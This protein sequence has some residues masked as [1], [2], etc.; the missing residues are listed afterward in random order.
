MVIRGDSTVEIFT[1]HIPAPYPS[2]SHAVVTHISQLRLKKPSTRRW[3]INGSPLLKVRITSY[4][5]DLSSSWSSFS[6]T[7][8]YLDSELFHLSGSVLQHFGL[9]RKQQLCGDFQFQVYLRVSMSTL[10][11]SVGITVD[12]CLKSLKSARYFSND[13]FIWNPPGLCWSIEVKQLSK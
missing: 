4:P 3:N 7:F 11:K 2:M 8:E 5:C 10:G 1:R 12:I 13:C 9:K 6:S